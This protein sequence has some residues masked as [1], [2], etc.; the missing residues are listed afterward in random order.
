MAAV[1]PKIDDYNNYVYYENPSYV[2]ESYRE[3]NML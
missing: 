2:Y 1:S 3:R